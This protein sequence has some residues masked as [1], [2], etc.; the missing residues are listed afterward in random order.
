[1]R[2]ALTIDVLRLTRRWLGSGAHGHVPFAEGESG[3]GLVETTAEEIRA[4]T[5]REQI[6]V[7]YARTERGFLQ[8]DVLIG[9]DH[10]GG[11]F[12]C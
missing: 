1:M 6:A 8:D 5:P 2:D 4:R 11:D 12:G 9:S 7:F 3:R 10:P